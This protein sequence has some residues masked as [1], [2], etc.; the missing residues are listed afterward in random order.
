MTSRTNQLQTKIIKDI[1]KTIKEGLLPSSSRRPGFEKYS[2]FY[3]KF[4]GFDK[5]QLGY[6]IFSNYRV[7]KNDSKGIKLTHLG[8]EL[9]KR[10]YDSYEFKHDII[11]TPKMY[12]ALD[13]H[14]QWPYYFTK[15]K[16]VLYSQ[17]DAA[18]YRMNENNIED[19]IDFIWQ[20]IKL[21]YNIY[22]IKRVWGIYANNTIRIPIYIRW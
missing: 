20:Y 11:P 19:F 16:M 12:L 9:L 17:E 14:M 10:Q 8:N 22:I 5:D 3:H 4:I 21:C 18:W 15:R 7:D 1:I 2:K 13:Q 6:K